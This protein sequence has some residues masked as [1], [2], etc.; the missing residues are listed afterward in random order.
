M[1]RSKKPL[2]DANNSDVK[3]GLEDELADKDEA[4]VRVLLREAREQQ[5]VQAEKLAAVGEL[6]ASIAHEINNPLAV[7]LGH[8]DLAIRELGPAAWSVRSEVDV[9]IQQIY[10]V[11][12]IIDSLLC[13]AGPARDLELLMPENVQSLVQESIRLVD[14]QAKLIDVEVQ[15][16]LQATSS[17]TIG[18]QDL[19]QVIVNL[20][21]NALHALEGVDRGRIVVRSRN[22]EG[23]GIILSVSDNGPGVPPQLA[24]EIF[25]PFFTTKGPG[26][27]SGLGMAVSNGLIRRYGGSL[28][29]SSADGQGAEFRIAALTQPVLSDRETWLAESLISSLEVRLKEQL[30]TGNAAG[31]IIP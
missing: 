4:T 21:I 16:D 27:G 7:M 9:V 20:L 5:L 23:Q 17:I 18:S 25:K 2:F 24:E 26:K 30:K 10:R 15:T 28:E 13:I 1:N 14:H 11:Q 31:P 8:V 29:L 19:Q 6:I 3:S 22:W 12:K